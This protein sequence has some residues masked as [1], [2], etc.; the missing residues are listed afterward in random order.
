MH[1]NYRSYLHEESEKEREQREEQQQQ[2]V[3]VIQRK[4]MMNR[5]IR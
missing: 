3:E 1:N 4:P 2:V 5:G